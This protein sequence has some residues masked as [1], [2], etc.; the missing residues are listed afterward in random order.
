[1]YTVIGRRTA[2]INTA[3]GKAMLSE[4]ANAK[5]PNRT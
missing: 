3:M 4:P 1:M 2:A 5:G